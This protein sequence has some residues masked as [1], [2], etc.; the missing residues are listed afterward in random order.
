M[1][2]K[3]YRYSLLTC[4]VA[5]CVLSSYFLVISINNIID[6]SKEDMMD[7]IMYILCFV[8]NLVFLGLEI[9]NTI[10]SFKTGSHFAKNLTYDEDNTFNK[11]FVIIILNSKIIKIFI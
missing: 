11:K 5:C 4:L 6:I 1:K 2:L 7:G 8:L 9:F 10:Y 3:I